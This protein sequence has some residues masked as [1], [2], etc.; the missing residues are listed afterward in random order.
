MT[1]PKRGGEPKVS[2]EEAALPSQEQAEELVVLDQAPMA[3][4]A[5]DPRKTQVL[6]PAARS[7]MMRQKNRG[8]QTRRSALQGVD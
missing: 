6:G 1:L 3:L 2:L 8:P 7:P 4:E 5:V